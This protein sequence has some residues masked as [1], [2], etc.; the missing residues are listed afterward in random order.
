MDNVNLPLGLRVQ[1]QIPLDVKM[2]S[3]SE[4]TLSNLGVSNNLAY[5]YVEGLIVY[6]IEEKTR[7]EWREAIGAEIGL[8]PTNFTYPDNIIVFGI[9]YSNREFNFFPVS[10][11]ILDAIPFQ[12]ID[13]GNGIGITIRGR[14]PLNYGNI[15]LQAFDISFSDEP[16]NTY[17]ATGF[18]AFAQGYQTIASND[19]AVAIGYQTEAQGFA[20]MAQGFVTTAVGDYSHTE[21][22]NATANAFASHAEGT[23]TTA[24]AFYSHAE[25]NG[26]QANGISSHAEGNGTIASGINSH[27]E[28]INTTASGS[29]SH[30]EGFFTQATGFNSHSSGWQ[31]VALG[32]RSFTAGIGNF[33]NSYGEFSIG[34]YGLNTPG[35]ATTIVAT[36]RLFNIGNGT[37]DIIRA[38]AFTILKN[39][40]A[41]LP[42]VTNALISAASG[43]AIVTKEYLE[44]AVA[45]IGDNLQKV[46]NTDYTL[47]NADNNYVIFINNVA[48]I[49]ITL[50]T[51]ITTANFCVGFVQKGA[52][53][54][55]V[56]FSA[57]GVT[58]HNPIGFKLKGQYYQAFIERE[59]NTS[60]FYLL[61]NVKL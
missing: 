60:D 18:L 7:W 26:T 58:L 40:L 39:G 10:E 35:N 49:T 25:G 51:A 21:G 13:E 6:C 36:D 37:S 42:S 9:D 53:I 31:T 3:P 57:T 28:G 45:N 23:N 16:D 33:A 2:Y 41:T 15:G 27:A 8:R 22:N 12:K 55:T 59:L 11:V 5:T 19:T 17:G 48:P 56:T 24:N 20:S 43:K 29:H 46:I 14:D 32:D 47:T 50:N 54:N 61:G 44:T 30:A 4:S 34:L 38:N 1:T 52:D